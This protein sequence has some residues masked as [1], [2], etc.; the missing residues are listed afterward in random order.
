MSVPVNFQ[1]LTAETADA[2]AAYAIV[3]AKS[4]L[5]MMR[6]LGVAPEGARFLEIGPGTDFGPALIL[7]SLGASVILADR[8]LSEWQADH[9]RPLYR[10]LAEMWPG[11]NAQIRAAAE[12]GYEA[13]NL[14]RLA[15]PAENLASIGD[16]TIDFTYSNAVLE[17]I[18]DVGTV[19]RELARVMKPGAKGAHQIDLRDHRTPDRPLEHLVLAETDFQIMALDRHNE[20]GNRLRASE[21]DAHWRAQGL[22][23]VKRQLDD[24]DGNYLAD[25]L[26]RLRKARSAY[27]NWPPE[28]AR[29][30]F[31]IFLIE[32]PAEPQADDAS[33]A[34]LALEFMEQT[35]AF[36]L[37]EAMHQP[38]EERGDAHDIVLPAEAFQGPDGYMWQC[39]LPEIPEGDTIGVAR[40]DA[41]LL[42]DGIPLGP[43]GSMH[44]LIREK[45]AGRYSHWQRSVY[46]ST[47]DGASPRDNGRTYVLRI[48]R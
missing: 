26:P 9:H 35:K 41:V 29:T 4:Q 5:D 6:Q 40:S 21:F 45:G 2:A 1:P 31:A 20:F 25:V 37:A 43:T 22:A 12:G 8:F 47:R 36:S 17:H 30:I 23:V 34:K 46:M 42:E 13:T 24:A 15:E 48:K 38:P 3:V 18:S 32:K 16:S 14:I 7:A 11:P 27:R 28:D 39:S 33:R 10:R 19:T 44:D